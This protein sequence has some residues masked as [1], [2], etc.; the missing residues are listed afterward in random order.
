MNCR[1]PTRPTMRLGLTR[2]VTLVVAGAGMSTTQAVRADEGGVSFWMP[3]QYGSFVAAPADPGRSFAM[4]YYHASADSDAA[5][6]FPRGGRLTAGLDVDADL[7]LLAPSYAMKT[8]VV[9]GQLAF[10]LAGYVGSVAVGTTA[11][12]QGP[13]GNTFSSGLHDS[14]QA[15]GDLY[16]SASLKWNHSNHN[17]MLYAMA[18][19][20]V[21]SYSADRLANFGTNHWSF[22]AGGGYTYLDAT[23]GRE[24]S[25]ALGFTHSWENPD[26]NYRNGASAHLDWAASQFLSET[27][28]LGLTGYFYQQI[29]GD[30]GE[31]AVLGDFKSRVSGIGPQV[32]HFF[33]VGAR[34]VYLNAKAIHEFNARNRPAGWNAWLTVSIPLSTPAPAGPGS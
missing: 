10:S 3:G 18:G 32:G 33:V 1:I 25:A 14:L 28:H 31:G 5:L 26:T 6:R 4:V 22:D 12:I 16:P 8:P 15:I 20:P 24:F 34:K 13:L 7:L 21:G 29:S 27:T 19:V 2:L 9:G 11:V 30:S 17:T 23:K